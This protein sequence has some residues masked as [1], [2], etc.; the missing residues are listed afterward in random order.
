M[1]SLAKVLFIGIDAADKDL[2]QLW[3]RAGDL[4]NLNKLFE[5]AAWG[6][7]QSPTGLYVG[8]IWPSFYTAVSP[9]R[10]ARFC[11]DQLQ[12]G[13]YDIKRFPAR[14]VKKEPFWDALNRSGKRVAIIDVPKTYPSQLFNGVHIV[15]WGSHDPDPEGFCVWPEAM[16]AEI[17][18]RFGIDTMHNC[19]A[20]RTTGE[21]FRDFRDYLIRRIRKKTE[22]SAWYLEQGNWDCFM[23]VFSES[24]CVGH[25]C[26]HLHDD[27][28]QKYDPHLVDVAGDP[29][30]EV[31]KAID[32][33]IGELIAKAGADT[34][35]MVFASHGMGPHYDAT[36]MLD[37]I[38]RRL[39]GEPPRQKRA[40]LVPIAT[41]LWKLLPQSIRDMASPLR[42]KARVT[43]GVEKISRL[44]TRRYFQIPNNDAYGGIRINLAGREPRGLVSPG[45]EYD[46][47]C[48]TITRDL[49]DF[50][51]VTTGEPLVKAVLR[52]ADL[53]EGENSHYL[54]D[55]LVEWNRSAPVS[56]IFSLK[57]GRI[58]G[59]YRKCRTGDHT[60]EGLYFISGPSIAPGQLQAQVS[61]MD[62]A[63][64]IASLTGV[65]LA[66][67]DGRSI[68]PLIGISQGNL[69]M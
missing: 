46:E 16:A 63:P 14:E 24:H 11:Y 40:F 29:I 4:P 13:S 33:G 5:T 22:L 57:A 30:K 47:V 19:N 34:H 12:P 36:F 35:V 56:E 28:H 64:T 50:T 15:D 10:H 68:A 2:I 53:Y 66:D 27:Q 32:E 55:L 20:F 48:E 7:T 41:A 37:D 52:C 9:A 65:E 54:P 43:L 21:E 39:E 25:Q 31:Y 44:D 59:E 1:S 23:T 17:G 26:W 58:T 60:S 45:K 6:I 38:L 49:M 8:A 51:N 42:S 62:L 61:V 69:P 3:T 67:V 18:K